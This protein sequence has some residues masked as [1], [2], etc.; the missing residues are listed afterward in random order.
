M[1]IYSN[2]YLNL[3]WNVIIKDF[4]KVYSK[5]WDNN[6]QT[7]ETEKLKSLFLNRVLRNAPNEAEELINELQNLIK[8]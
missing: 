2:D 7:K 1:A 8:K 6:L 4:S 5:I 3:D